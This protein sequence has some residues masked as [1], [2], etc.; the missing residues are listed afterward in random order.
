MRTKGILTLALT[1]LIVA[2]IPLAASAAS[3]SQIRTAVDNNF[4][5]YIW[6]DD[7]S[8]TASYN[9]YIT[10]TMNFNHWDQNAQGLNPRLNWDSSS[11]TEGS[12]WPDYTMNYLQSYNAGG[13]SRVDGYGTSVPLHMS[14]TFHQNY[15]PYMNSVGQTSNP[16]FTVV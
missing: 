13:S 12:N 14:C 5:T 6:Q 7:Q 4:V 10:W 9:E 2:A 11:S 8:I 16:D 3:F 15:Y 1:A